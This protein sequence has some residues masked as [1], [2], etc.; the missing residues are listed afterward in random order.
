MPT[1]WRHTIRVAAFIAVL[2]PA[3]A[4]PGPKFLPGDP[5]WVDP[6]RVSIPEPRKIELKGTTTSKS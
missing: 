6:D 5:V 3:G 1:A 2:L 4:A